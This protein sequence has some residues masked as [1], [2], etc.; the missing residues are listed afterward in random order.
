MI[1]SLVCQVNIEQFQLKNDIEYTENDLNGPKS[2]NS[3]NFLD[4]RCYFNFKAQIF[5]NWK[6]VIMFDALNFRT[7]GSIHRNYVVCGQFWQIIPIFQ[8]QSKKMDRSVL[9]FEG[10]IPL[11]DLMSP[12]KWVKPLLIRTIYLT[13]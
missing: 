7:T 2:V 5:R 1:N 8:L 3:A 11:W 10:M 9:K 4:N 13:K 6:N 12:E